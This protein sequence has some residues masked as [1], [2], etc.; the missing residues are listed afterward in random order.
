MRSG[1]VEVELADLLLDGWRSWLLWLEVAGEHG[2]ATS[3]DEAEM[4]RQDHGR[5]LGFTRVVAR[6]TA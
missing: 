3:P 1:M 6:R 4:L 2:F 5:T